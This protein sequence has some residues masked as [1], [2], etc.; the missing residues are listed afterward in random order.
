MLEEIDWS[1]DEEDYYGESYVIRDKMYLSVPID[2]EGKMGMNLTIIRP[3]I[4]K[5]L[6]KIF[7][8]YDSEIDK[9]LKERMDLK[10]EK[11]RD[12]MGEKI[13][14]GGIKHKA[15][16]IFELELFTE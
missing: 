8:F 6:R 15:F 11:W 5:I 4:K 14:F 13:R 2:K 12:V 9:N 16:D 7:R 10:G 1:I 3:T